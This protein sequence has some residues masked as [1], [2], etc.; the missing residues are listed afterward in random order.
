MAQAVNMPPL[1]IAEIRAEWQKLRSQL[2]TASA[3]PVD[4]LQRNWNE[5]VLAAEQEKVS[6]FRLSSLLAISAIR[7]LPANVLWLSRA[8]RSAGRRTGE[9]VVETVLDSYVESLREIRRTGHLNF[10][11]REFAPY[12]RATTRQFSRGHISL[13]EKLLGRS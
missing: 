6:V 9:V 11:V 4:A 7:K 3:L 10:W 13:T 12:I 8:S 2:P 5:L 1:N